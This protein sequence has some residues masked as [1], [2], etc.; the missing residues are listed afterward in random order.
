MNFCEILDKML[1]RK[2]LIGFWVIRFLIKELLL[3]D[4]AFQ[5]EW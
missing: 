5:D 2:Y 3:S 4:F 1:P